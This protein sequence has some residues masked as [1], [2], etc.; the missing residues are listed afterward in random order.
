MTLSLT[1]PAVGSTNWGTTV[2]VNWQLIQDMLNGCLVN[3]VIN[4][5]FD[6]FQRTTPGTYTT[7]SDNKYGPDRWRSTRQTADIQTVRFDGTGVSGLNSKN[8]GG[9]KQITA[10]GKF[11]VSQWI[12]N[13][14]SIPRLSRTVTFQ[15]KMKATSAKTIRIGLMENQAAG[16]ADSI[17]A[18]LVTSWNAN[19]TNPTLA[20][21]IAIIGIE[22]VC[23]VTTNFSIFS[24]S[25]T[26]PSNSK[27][28]AVALWT[29]S[30]FNANDE[31]H[32]AEAGLYN[33]SSTETPN[34]Y[35]RSIQ[36]EFELCQR[37]F[38]KSYDPDVLPGTSTSTGRIFCRNYAAV[39]TD[40]YHMAQFKCTK[41]VI[42]TITTY[43]ASTGTSGYLNV[44]NIGTYQGLLWKNMPTATVFDG[45]WTADSDM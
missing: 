27:N 25:V 31:L 34:W 11:H 37:Y 18:T 39:A 21:N 22:T 16:T 35:P 12:E 32:V 33:G 36:Q 4:G 23:S 7:I 43:E 44:D 15:I 20:T 24:C 1:Q 14:D 41:R 45:Q 38:E 19:G 28:I 10:A 42:P 17:P 5:G 8:Y 30:Q 3:P 13:V 29:D 9:F 2:N 26:V 6:Y 40:T